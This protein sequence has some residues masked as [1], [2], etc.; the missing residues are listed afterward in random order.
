MEL[1]NDDIRDIATL[2]R[3]GITD[4]EVTSYQKD[5]SSVLQYFEKLQQ[6]NTDGIEEIGHIT[7][8]DNVYRDDQ[9]V[10]TSVHEREAIMQNVREQ[11]NGYIKVKS[12]L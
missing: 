2:A 8:I 4:A 5:L 10:E 3:I 1:T 12:V 7:G 9:A 6:V 11:H